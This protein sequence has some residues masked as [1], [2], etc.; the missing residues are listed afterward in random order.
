VPTRDGRRWTLNFGRPVAGAL[1][2]LVLVL[3]VLA[4][5]VLIAL[6]LR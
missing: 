2:G 3:G 5:T 6:A 1:L 4:P